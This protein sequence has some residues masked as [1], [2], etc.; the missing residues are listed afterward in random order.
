MVK[1]AEGEGAEVSD[2][3]MM[4]WR[5]RGGVVVGVVDDDLT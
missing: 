2:G 3:G 1:E 5:R 4:A